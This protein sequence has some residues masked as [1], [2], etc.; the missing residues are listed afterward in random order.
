MWPPPLPAAARSTGANRKTP[1]PV[2]GRRPRA[3]RPGS[4]QARDPRRM[5]RHICTRHPR[6]RFSRFGRCH[7]SRR[8]I[9]AGPPRRARESA[10]RSRARQT[11]GEGSRC[12]DHAPDAASDPSR[13]LVAC[14]LRYVN[15][16]P[17]R[18]A[19]RVERRAFRGAVWIVPR[20]PPVRGRFRC[21]ISLACMADAQT[22][23]CAML[24]TRTTA[25]HGPDPR[26][27]AAPSRPETRPPGRL[28]TWTLRRPPASAAAHPSFARLASSRSITTTAYNCSVRRASASVG[29]SH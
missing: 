23:P 26:R 4:L 8:L 27:V 2:H 17:S 18:V 22:K 6:P 29:S 1:R 5:N 12:D 21:A 24:V 25:R 3:T 20:C 16:R 14:S 28:A 13:H 7:R 11:P 15:G 10:S 19:R 9:L